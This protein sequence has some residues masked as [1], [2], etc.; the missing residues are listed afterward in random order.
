MN[1]D[2]L[3]KSP[4]AVALIISVYFGLNSRCGIGCHFRVATE[5]QVLSCVAIAMA[6]MPAHL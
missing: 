1:A 4:Q 2:R 5:K 3:I 6:S